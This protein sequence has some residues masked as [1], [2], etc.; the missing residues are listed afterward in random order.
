[1]LCSREMALSKSQ[2]TALRVERRALRDAAR[3][4]IQDARLRSGIGFAAAYLG[5]QVLPVM[6]PTLAQYQ[7][8]IDL[9]LA[10]GGLYY[11]FSDDSEMGD[12]GLGVGLVGA[13][14]TLDSIGTKIIDWWTLR[15][16]D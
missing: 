5:S 12:Y 4:Q 6:L 9:V 2:R 13:T 3:D 7:G 16:N 10:G 8:T 15:Q 11:A 14:Q 1:M